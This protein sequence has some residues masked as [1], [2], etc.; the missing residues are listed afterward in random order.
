MRRN[1]LSETPITDLVQPPIHCNRRPSNP[2]VLVPTY[3]PKKC[4]TLRRL[5][6]DFSVKM[7]MS[8]KT[9]ADHSKKLIHLDLAA[10]SDRG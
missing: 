7:P 1:Q 2:R 8:L 4:L 6:V 10:D 3:F 5:K 9:Y